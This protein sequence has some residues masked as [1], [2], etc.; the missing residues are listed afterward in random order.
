MQFL[1]AWVA[2]GLAL[3]A[4]WNGDG[5]WAGAMLLLGLFAIGLDVRLRAI[6][7]RLPA[8]WGAQTPPAGGITLRRGHRDAG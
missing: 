3:A 6:E 1:T 4:C 2:F 5:R 7:R 8:T